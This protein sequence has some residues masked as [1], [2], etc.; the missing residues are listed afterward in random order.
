MFI[1]IWAQAPRVRG[2]DCI[3]F[4]YYYPKLI[5]FLGGSLYAQTH[6]ILHTLVVNENYAFYGHG[7]TKMGLVPPTFIYIY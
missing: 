3:S 7:Y 1:M 4:Y 2:P 6:E 5:A